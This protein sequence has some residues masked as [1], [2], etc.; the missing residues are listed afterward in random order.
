MTALN[1]LPDHG[2]RRRRARGADAPRA[3]RT[4][5]LAR[6]DLRR[7]LHRHAGA[8]GPVGPRLV[9]VHRWSR[10]PCRRPTS[11]TRS[12]S[13]AIGELWNYQDGLPT[14]LFNSAGDGVA[15]DRLLPGADDSRRLR[16]GALPDSGQG[17]LLRLPAARADHPLS[18]ADHADLLHVRRAEA[19]QLAGRPRDRAHRDP[20]AVQRSTSC[21]TASRR[22][23]ASSRRRR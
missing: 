22:C 5:Y 6:R 14:Y 3:G 12:A 17:G 15:D 10:R 18:G 7:A 9:Q 13:T 16:A 8:A 1:T 11:R 23:R 21:A 20:D 2:V 4:K 19:D